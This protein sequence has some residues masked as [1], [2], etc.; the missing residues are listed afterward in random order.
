LRGSTLVSCVDNGMVELGWHDVNLKRSSFDFDNLLSALR[1]ERGGIHPGAATRYSPVGPP[2]SAIPN[3]YGY[4][5]QENH[6]G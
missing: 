2:F 5:L 3:A 1:T 4:F 6:H